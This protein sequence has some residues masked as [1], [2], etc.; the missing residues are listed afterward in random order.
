M[1]RTARPRLT[2]LFAVLA[3]LFL[4]L[5]SAPAQAQDGSVPAQPTGLSTE[6]F[7]DRVNLTWD[8]PGDGSI[9]HY[10][11]LRRD[12]DVHDAGEFVTI[13]SDTG[14][15]ATSYTDD[16]VEPEK[17]YVY[18]VK[19]VN[20][21]GA[22]RWSSFARAN[23]PAAPTP[24]PNSP[25]T[26]APTI[27]GTVQ[28]GETLTAATSGIAD[29]DGLTNVSFSYQWLAEDTEVAGATNSTYTPV[30]ADV[31]KTIKLRVSFTDDRDFEESLTSAATAAVA[32]KPNSPATGQPAINGTVQVG[33]TLTAD[34]SGIADA[35]GLTNV[36]YSYQW[37]RNDGSA[38]ADISGATDST[39]TPVDADV[40]KTVKVRVSF[41]DD[42][43]N[44]ESLTSTATAPIAPAAD[45]TEP[46]GP[47]WSATLTVG[48][49]GDSYG[50]QGFLNPQAGSLVPATFVLDGVTYTVGHIETAADYLTAFGVDRELPVAFTL[51]LDGARF[52][53]TD[54]SLT[55]TTY[56]H[57]YTWLGRGADLKVGEEVTALVVASSTFVG[58]ADPDLA[59]GNLQARGSGEKVTLTWDAPTKDA[60]SV[61][62]Y[63]ILRAQG[64]GELETLVA[65]TRSTGADYTDSDV[66]GNLTE[67]RYQVKALRGGEASRG[68]NVA[69]VIQS[70]HADAIVPLADV[71][72]VSNM[73]QTTSQ[74]EN[75]ENYDLAQ[76]FTTGTNSLGYTLESVAFRYSVGG[77][78]VVPTHTVSI[79]TESSDSPGSSLVT[80]TNPDPI[81]NGVN[82]YTTTDGI[83]LSANTTY[84]I[85][86]DS[87][88]NAGDQVPVL[89]TAADSEDSGAASGW[90]IGN[91]SI[92]RDHDST[93]SWATF[94]D[95]F[96]I[97][98]KGTVT[99]E[100]ASTDATLSGLVLNDGTNDLTLTPNFVSGTMSYAASV[101]NAVS[102]ITVTPETNDSN[103]SVKY[104]DGND[105]EITDADGTATG[106]QVDLVVGANTIKVKVTAEDDATTETYTVVVTREAA[107][108]TGTLVSNA[109]QTST[110][111]GVNFANEWAHGFFTGSNSAG[112]NLQNI[113]LDIKLAFGQG[114]SVEI[115]S[116]KN[117]GQPNS[118][119]VAL[120][121]PS[122]ITTATGKQLFAAPANTVLAKQTRYFVHIDSTVVGSIESTTSTTDDS[123]GAD[124]WS[125]DDT[126]FYRVPGSG[127]SWRTD[128][129]TCCLLKFTVNGAVAT[130]TTSTDATLSGLV[131]NDGTNDLTLT[132]AFATGTLSYAASVGNAVSQITVTPETNDSNASVKYLDGSNAEI[133]DADGTATGHQ[134]ALV[135]GANTIKVKVTAEDDATTETYTVVVTREAA[136][137]TGAL[138]SNMGQTAASGTANVN[139]TQSQGQGFTTG[140]NSGGYTLDSVELDV[141]IFSGTESHITV[142]IYSESSG[143]PGTLVHTLT[144]PASISLAVTTFTAPSGATLAASTTYYV[145]ITTTDSGISFSRTAAT[146]EDTG[147][148]SGWSIAD[149]RRFTQTGSWTTATLPTRMRI[150]GLA[151]DTTS[152][153]ATLSGLV[154]N[155]GTS[156]LTLTPTFASGTMSYAASVGNAVSQITVTPE[157]NDSNASVKYLAGNGAEITDADGTATGQQVDIVVGGNTIK[158]KVTAEDDATTETY[159][160][161]VTREVAAGAALVSNL[162]QAA[163]SAGVSATDSKDLAQG[164]TTGSR[165]GGY[166]L[167]SVE[168][169]VTGFTGTASDVTVSIYSESGNDPNTAVHALTTPASI[170]GLTTFT[171]PS[172]ASLAADTQYYVVITT[173][174]ED[175]TLSRTDS[176]ADDSGGAAGWSIQDSGR[177]NETEWANTVRPLRIRIKGLATASDDATLSDL[178]LNYGTNDLTLTPT[179]ASG[180]TSYTAEVAY[181]IGQLTLTPTKSDSNADVEYLDDDDMT[182]ADADTVTTG[183]QVDLEE[184]AN[185]IKVKVTAEDYVATETYEVTVTR[186]T[187]RAHCDDTEVWCETMV[188]GSVGALM[189]WDDAG[190]A[191]G[192][193]LSADDQDFDYGVHTYDFL[194]IYL[195][196]STLFIEFNTGSPGDLESRRTRDKLVF[197]VDGQEFNLGAGELLS[198]GRGVTWNSTNLTWAT[199]ETVALEV[200]E[201]E[202][203][204]VATLEDLVVNDGTNDLTLMPTFV[205]GTKGYTVAVH[206]AISRVTVTP[207]LSH[208][209]AT[210]EYLDGS[211]NA[212]ADADG[213]T[214]GQQ[215]DLDTGAN[216]I[217]VKVTA[218]DGMVEEPYTVVVT[219][220]DPPAHCDGTEI[221]CETMTPG[222]YSEW[223]GWKDDGTYSGAALATSDENFDYGGHTYNLAEIALASTG[224][225]A[226][227]L[228]V[229]FDSGGAGDL[230]TKAT[231]DKLTL[232]VGGQALNFGDATYAV[233]TRTLQWDSTALTWTAGTDVALEI[234]EA[235][236]TAAA[237]ATLISNMG[238]TAHSGNASV[239]TTQ[240]QGQGFTTGADSGGYTLGS[241]E[242]DV[243]L[244]TGTAS[245]ITVS[246]YSESS[247]NPGT[248]VHT[249][250]TPASISQEVTTFTAPS[251]ATLAASTTYYVVITTTDS[252]I[253]FSRTAATAEDT[254]GTSGWSIADDRRWNRGS[255]STATIPIR[256]RING[257]AAAAA[258]NLATGA[259]TISGTP[260]VGELLTAGTSGIADAD[261]LNN[262]SYS[263]QWIA[264]DGTD[265]SDIDDATG[266]TYRPLLAHL[267]QTIKV[268]VKFTDDLDNEESLTSAATAAVAASTYG[269]VIWAATLTVEEETVSGT[270]TFFGFSIGGRGSLEPIMFTHD[271]T[272]TTVTGLQYLE[273]GTLRFDFNGSLGS[274][275]FNLYLDGDPFLIESP[276]TDNSFSFSDHGLTWADGQ[277]VE[278]RLTVNRPATGTPAVTG[279]VQVGELLTADT[280]NIGDPDGIT[281]PTFSYQWISNDGTDDSDIDGATDSTYRP[282]QA[283]AG[284]TIKVRVSFTDDAN[285]PEFL[286]S[287]ATTAVTASPYGQ[288]IWSATLTVEEFTISPNTYLGYSHAGT[289]IGDLDPLT[290][291]HDGNEITVNNLWYI[292]G[293][294]LSF[295]ISQELS[296]EGFLLR[297]GD[298]LLQLGEPIGDPPAYQF[299]GHGLSWSDGDTVEVR[300]IPNQ[301][302]TGEP[303][304]T[305]TPQ[306]GEQLTA[307][308]SAIGDPDGITNATF[309]Y[310]WIANDGTDD[311]DID[312]ATGETYRPLLAHLG[313]TIKVRV[314]FTDDNDYTE[315][316][317]SGY[318]VAVYLPEV[319][320]DSSLVPDGLVPG[321]LFR[322]IF[323]SSET[324]NASP[325]NI[326]TYNTWV[327]DLV[328]NGHADIQDHSSTFRVV[329]STPSVDARDNTSTTYT[330]DDKGLPIYWLNGDKA[331]D[332]YKDFYD[333]TWDEEASMRDESGT[334]VT[335]PTYVW[336]G[337]N[338]NGTKRSW[339]LGS[340]TG[341][342][343]VG[344]PNSNAA[345]DGPLSSG[346]SLSSSTNRNLYALSGV[347]QVS[348]ITEVPAD[349]SLVPDGLQEGDQFRLLF[350]SS[351]HRNASPSGI[352]TYN[353]WIQDLAANGH[354]DIQDYS[355]SFRAVGS[356]EDTDARDNTRTTYTT[357]DKGVA[358]Y[359]LGGNKVA[360]EY[361]D[362]YDETWDEEAS[363][364]NES[365]T[366]ESGVSAWTGSDHDGT[367][368]LNFNDGSSRALGNSG[369]NRVRF[370]KTDSS[371]HGPLSGE[372]ANRSGNKRIYG[373]S[374]VFEVAVSNNPPT[375]APAISGTVQVGGVLTAVTSGIADADGITNATFSYQWIANDGTDGSDIA[376]A[377]G[378]T[379]R[380]VTADEGKTIKVRVSFTDD[381]D[382]E[383]SLSSAATGAVSPWDKGELIWSA[384]LTVGESSVGGGPTVFGFSAGSTGSLEPD[385]FPYADTSITITGLLYTVPGTRLQLN[386]AI[387]DQQALGSGAFRLYLDEAHWLVDNPAHKPDLPIELPLMGLS[388]TD[389]QE[390]EVRLT[391]NRAPTAGP[392]ITGDVQ[393]GG[394]LTADPSAIVDPDGIAASATYTYQWVRVDGMT[395]T[396]ITGA[397][398]STYTLVAD[399]GGKTIKVKV[400][401]TDEANFVD[402]ATSDATA[403]VATKP[404]PPTS[405]GT[406]GPGNGEL[407]VEWTAPTDDGGSSVTGYKVQWKSGTQSFGSS[408]QATAGATATSHKITGLTNG[409][410]YTVRVKA[411][412]AVGDSAASSTATGTPSTTPGA[413]GNVQASGNAELVVTWDA[414]TDTGGSAVTGYTVQWKSGS[415]S[416]NTTRQATVT[417]TTHTIPTLTNGTEYT[418][419]VKATNANGDSD[420][421]EIT[422]TPASGPG[423]GTVTSGSITRTSAVITVTIANPDTNS[424]TV[425]LQYKRNADTAWTGVSP[426][427]TVSAA[428]TFNLSGLTG[429]TD[430][431]VRASL[432]STFASGVVTVTFKTSPTKPGPPTSVGTTGPGN[433][434]LTV[435]WTAPTDDGGSSV[436]GYKVQWKSGTQSFGSSRQ[437]SAGATATSHKITGLTNGTEY[438]VRVKATNSVGDGA[439]SDEAKGTPSTAPGKPSVDVTGTNMQLQVRWTV[440]DGGADLTGYTL[441][442]KESSVAGWAAAGVTEV[443]PAKDVTTYKIENL[444]NDTAYTVRLQATNANGDGAWF[445]EEQGTPTAKPPP[446]VTITTGEGEPI[447]GPFTF[448]VTFSEE[449]EGFEC[450]VRQCEIG[451]SYVGGAFVA[452]KDFQEVE[453]NSGGEHIFTA[454]VEDI[455]TGTLVIA[456]LEGKAQ[457]KAGGL[458]NAF[459]A[460]QVEVERP[461]LPDIPGVH[462][463]SSEMTPADIGGYLGYGSVGDLMGGSLA[464]DNF[465]WQGQ[466]YTVKAL[467]YNPAQVQLDLDQALPYRGERMILAVDGRWV[468]GSNP[469]QFGVIQGGEALLS[470]HWHPADPGFE[471]GQ[472]V[473][474]RLSRQAPN[475][476]VTRDYAALSWSDP[477]DDSITGYRI[478]RRDLDQDGEFTTL[479]S[480]T[481]SA[482]TG[483]TDR[484]VE[485]GGRYAYRVTAMNDYGES[486][487]SGPVEVDIPGGPPDQPTGLSATAA[488]EAVTLSWDD[489]QDDNITGYKVQ[490]KSGSEDYDGSGGSARQAEID[491]P[492]GRTHTVTGLSNGVEYR[493]RIIAVN[494][495]GDGAPSAETTGTPGETTRPELSTVT[496]ADATLTLTYGET[497]DQA[498]QPATDAFSV[499]VGGADRT[500]DVVSVAGRAVTLTLASEVAAEDTV[501]VSYTVPADAAAPRIR[502]EAGNGAASFSNRAVVNNTAAPANSPATGA[503]II[504]GTAQV[505][506]TLT[507]DTSSIEDADGLDNA[508]FVYQWLADDADIAGATS[509][510]YTLVDAD[511]EKAVKVRVIF[512]DNADNEET[513]TSEATAA[514]APR[515][516]SP[517]TG[518]PTISGT[519]Q[520]GETLT[521]DTSSI[522]DADGMSGAVFSYQ[523]L[524]NGADVA[525]ATSDTYTPVAD[526]GGKAIKV[527]V[528]FRDDRN[529]QES[530]TSAATAAVT[531]AANES[532]IWSATLTVGESYGFVGFW[533]GVCGALDP[534]E[535]SLDGNDYPISMFAELSGRYFQ[536]R[537]DQALPVAFTLRVGETTFESKD[538]EQL[539]GSSSGAYQW[540]GQLA[541]LTEGSTVEVSLTLAE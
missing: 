539:G 456:V 216:T 407:T 278:V 239:S 185:T 510:S 490:W 195:S 111:G 305:G 147:G 30:D 259:P 29:A 248:L 63:Q 194:S 338:H 276:G 200:V 182:I 416:F 14:S 286:T 436:T 242:L 160:V 440:A 507:V 463:W 404:G 297:L 385:T 35:D 295:E 437:A 263:Y 353:T 516:N 130:A 371:V 19:A 159:T 272:T 136:A 503:P 90:S 211:G 246:I 420:W 176:T 226:G 197:T 339:S 535:F 77:S 15:A 335:A 351:E 164:F 210:V 328:A 384:L 480:D 324:R 143:N 204:T 119:V 7:H 413:P 365:G 187:A 64:D 403:K 135:V 17:R 220:A 411:V 393:V 423:V 405:V 342:V 141:A 347:L 469:R 213:M 83:S 1:T 61:T 161:V 426:M 156:D 376:H 293:G 369:N 370:G 443:N 247:G 260:Q 414:P 232:N 151:A 358:I 283:D 56:S 11:V 422:A 251:G 109:G 301:A 52:E 44:P 46:P 108:Q 180:M 34:T 445:D 18:R 390:V 39:Y 327:Q 511:L 256:M 142:S 290:F 170:A 231:R 288:V 389:G 355:S 184:G 236:D 473:V 538:A 120:T 28:V 419:R 229:I 163:H 81:V 89:Q 312:G 439:W 215:V 149:D 106:Q 395:E 491:D 253:A 121:S 379:Y 314:T 16:S 269:Q 307:D 207:E 442:Y 493:F 343:T 192:G 331:A 486:E 202:V 412:N 174:G 54:A 173:A 168:L 117:N 252:G 323:L 91:S 179:F 364:K 492:A 169:D 398:A 400:S 410:E 476:L 222:S 501:T 26:G 435:E 206:N 304:I 8:D 154:L 88:P 381:L 137:Q 292:V 508:G 243:V 166:T 430:Y 78:T 509:D 279:D 97:R 540:T 125:I 237:P 311:S 415:Q 432:D 484:T 504:S 453:V 193:A 105:A 138:V 21:H 107:V 42:A 534:D 482:D 462:V 471:V 515:P 517:P 264:N 274:E 240:S 73:G 470:Y 481:G 336:T 466:T 478:E 483:Y 541:G 95:S 532:S 378:E 270:G 266:E 485:P 171:A 349:W 208:S 32:Q 340:T 294:L 62:G 406:T 514:V 332:H 84:F 530:L 255:W 322:L 172:N 152:T 375:G 277:K 43:S 397:T 289:G 188:V 101:G 69:G 444:N 80:L 85:V 287:A 537:L 201:A 441:Q 87:S 366:A 391:V 47:I 128:A 72:L 319:P 183:Q 167:G 190:L 5:T 258:N 357:S 267:G 209:W 350:I 123:G 165:S 115:W 418:V 271:G 494:D 329:G 74:T 127:S 227:R 285:F 40:G 198:N 529:H 22:S 321:D 479:V 526:D 233:A 498:S 417:T 112:Y 36:A 458:G 86:V 51:E 431:D 475:V 92:Y 241:V 10:E 429:N 31:G 468:T 150:N 388:W 133:T 448:T 459:G 60:G 118:Q 104:L 317:E 126:N 334:T 523:W 380:P 363:M 455:L 177:F 219:R 129:G 372:T 362:F 396:N 341:L 326:D 131:L 70:A 427:S 27:S 528:S 250:T 421:T 506:E 402:T 449:V 71:T 313:Q 291:T 383:E 467:L 495:D 146:A 428:V 145:V 110:S 361:E 189:G 368:A 114:I 302:P 139:T 75:L 502:D 155:D 175:V 367:E 134:V 113:E 157:T 214:E 162:G 3:A 57:L 300:L 345:A 373:L 280:S 245:H 333:E 531:A 487:P 58:L 23:T 158:V 401:Y 408:R 489:P 447:R 513:L 100:T 67:Y 377:T 316:L 519:A 281:N 527:K 103:A 310:Q 394:T 452:V 59:P 24:E 2:I 496:V 465:H 94:D 191:V 454:R 356:T 68:S 38:D 178:V 284:K 450:P 320:A 53:S 181:T 522:D 65:D 217:E 424:Q 457:A 238:Q 451:A 257:P 296:G 374:G 203:S 460:M 25:A 282:V 425:N 488:S 153:D 433:G 244:F 387:A 49:V 518:A 500:V 409:T 464:V 344:K 98:I 186:E 144:T 96:K 524:A 298:T 309:S 37:T 82:T 218:E 359:W 360:D 212:I 235:S 533:K 308:I 224:P 512:T 205:S 325:S 199:G 303:A 116:A 354:T 472:S 132:P 9:T 273:G 299:S 505:D 262:V 48:R 536:F 249:L 223:L 446:S 399:D 50:Y 474:V 520:V 525:G 318:T 234:V 230:A 45:E 76:A 228:L 20:Q 4:S 13:E 382:N 148:A 386:A 497:L 225:S 221:W 477:Q 102:Q 461:A 499:A 434:E 12:R 275:D 438:T 352:A 55:S 122:G 196:G 348:L 33:E 337:S 66:S 99:E 392:T 261:G 330:D 6:A 268:R 79:W 254:G 346:N 306:V 265:D 140:S 41:T 521:V 124:G 315:T 93:G